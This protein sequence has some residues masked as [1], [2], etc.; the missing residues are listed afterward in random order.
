MELAKTDTK[1]FISIE[2][3]KYDIYTVNSGKSISIMKRQSFQRNLIEVEKDMF[4]QD[5][6]STSMDLVS[7]TLE[8]TMNTVDMMLV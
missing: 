6:K 7:K 5:N 8:K 2:D 1:D 3:Y 4:S